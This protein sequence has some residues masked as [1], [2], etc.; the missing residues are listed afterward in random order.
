MLGM[1]GRRWTPI[2]SPKG[3]EQ[4]LTKPKLRL[5]PLMVPYRRMYEETGALPAGE[6][7]T[8]PPVSN[9]RRRP[10]TQEESMPLYT[11][12]G[13]AASSH[14]DVEGQPRGKVRGPRVVEDEERGESNGGPW[15]EKREVEKADSP[16]M[17]V[18]VVVVVKVV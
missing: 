15:E 4:C 11:Q 6:R 3:G 18:M 16:G 9:T 8:I 10:Y 14:A 12:E 2:S 5:L 13:T 1:E 7:D 17:V